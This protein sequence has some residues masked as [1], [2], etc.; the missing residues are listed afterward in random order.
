MPIIVSFRFIVCIGV[1]TKRT[2]PKVPVIPAFLPFH[3]LKRFADIN[4]PAPNKPPTPNS[5][6]R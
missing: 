3:P 6:A 2:V 1:E 4:A 5:G